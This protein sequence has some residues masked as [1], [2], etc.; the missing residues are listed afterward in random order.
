[1]INKFYHKNIFIQNFKA[2]LSTSRSEDMFKI[3]LEILEEHDD[4]KMIDMKEIFRNMRINPKTSE[5]C[6]TMI[7][8]CTKIVMNRERVYQESWY[9][10]QLNFRDNCVIF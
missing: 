7:T 4:I 8:E 9:D 6:L 1:M 3:F 2:I 10:K 5:R